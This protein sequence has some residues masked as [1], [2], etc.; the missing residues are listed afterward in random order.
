L[1]SNKNLRHNERFFFWYSASPRVPR[2]QG[3]DAKKIHKRAT[4]S[5]GPPFLLHVRCS[6]PSKTSSIKK[7]LNFTEKQLRNNYL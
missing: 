3:S 1:I 4:A 2:L 5:D 6:Y 7:Y